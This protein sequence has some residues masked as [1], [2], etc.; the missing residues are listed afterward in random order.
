MRKISYWLISTLQ[1]Y[2]FRRKVKELERYIPRD[3]R[4]NRDWIDMFDLIRKMLEYDPKKRIKLADAF[5]HP[6]LEKYNLRKPSR[7][8]SGYESR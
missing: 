7:S 5:A 6:F 3:Q 8:S 4:E 2:Y 1:P